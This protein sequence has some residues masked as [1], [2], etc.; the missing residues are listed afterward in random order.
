MRVEE[1]EEEETKGD[2]G[3]TLIEEELDGEQYEIEGEVML[4]EEKVGI[5]SI[6]DTSGR[7]T[8]IYE[9]GVVKGRE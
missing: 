3:E 5:G 7:Q 6:G 2:A 9:H 8:A 4:V 1:E